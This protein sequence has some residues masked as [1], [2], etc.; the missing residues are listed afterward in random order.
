MS[1]FFGEVFLFQIL[2]CG[3]SRA[4]QRNAWLI[5]HCYSPYG[6]TQL[7]KTGKKGIRLGPERPLLGPWRPSEGPGEADLIPTTPDWPAWVG[8][9]VNTHFDLVSGPFW[10]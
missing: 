10:A 7:E 1:K 2:A 4:S 6:T 9:M 3:V 8:F 5:Q